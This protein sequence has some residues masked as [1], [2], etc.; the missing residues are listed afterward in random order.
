MGMP[1]QELC[2]GSPLT[3]PGTGV[4]RGAS[5]QDACNATAEAENNDEEEAREASSYEEEAGEPIE[6]NV[7]VQ[8]LPCEKGTKCSHNSE[9]DVRLFQEE[10]AGSE[11][12]VR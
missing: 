3:A 7:E 9:F 4:E 8:L 11:R 6:T 10:L 2:G 5:A 1:P 12:K